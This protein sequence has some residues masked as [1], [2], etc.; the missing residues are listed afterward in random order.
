MIAFP[1]DI[2]HSCAVR[3]ITLLTDFGTKDWFVPSMKGVILGIAPRATI[4]DVTHEIPPQDV[5]AGAFILAAAAPTFPRG[6]IHVAVVDPGVGSA[7][8]AIAVR[9]SEH[10][11]VGPDNG[12]LSF[13]LQK[14]PVREIRLLANPR[15]WRTPVSRTFHGRD[16]FAPVAAHLARGAKFAALGTELKSIS[17][18]AIQ[19]PV[20]TSKSIRG[21]VIYVD[22]FGNLVTN[23]EGRSLSERAIIQLGRKR[24]HGL[25]KSYADASVGDCIAVV[26][27][28]N[29][30]EI[31]VRDGDAAAKL[32][33]KPGMCVVAT[34]LR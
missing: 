15:F 24:I 22:H 16:V 21:E 18:L 14:E 11:F 12:L 26:N 2:R 8:K 3:V 33:A 5:R 4:V 13:V 17:T 19:T 6:T 34:G 31:S 9:T 29:L 20:R 1:P 28:L 30:L 27:S 10:V 32:K 25:S 23:I 7:R